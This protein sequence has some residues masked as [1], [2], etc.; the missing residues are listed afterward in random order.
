MGG[1]LKIVDGNVKAMSFTHVGKLAVF[2][3]FNFVVE[4]NIS[5]VCVVLS[6]Y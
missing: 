1:C 5:G 3:C 2:G 4:V 6:Y